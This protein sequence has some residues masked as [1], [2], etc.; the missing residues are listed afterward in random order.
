MTAE[1]FLIHKFPSLNM[2][3]INFDLDGPTDNLRGTVI[4][5]ME[6]YASHE[7]YTCQSCGDSLSR[8][9]PT[10]KRLWES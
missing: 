7:N 8:D 5:L 9:C 2:L 6:E 3:M 1:E 4:S 10:C